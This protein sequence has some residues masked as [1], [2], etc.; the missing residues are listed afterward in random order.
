MLRLLECLGS[1]YASAYTDRPRGQAT[2]RGPY[3]MLPYRV[4]R[5]RYRKGRSLSFQD[6]ALVTATRI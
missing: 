2:R 3:R 6:A 4:L 1:F 5:Y